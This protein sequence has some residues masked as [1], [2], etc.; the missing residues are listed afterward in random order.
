MHSF[1]KHLLRAY[2]VP[3]TIPSASDTAVLINKP[4]PSWSSHPRK[5]RHRQSQEKQT[6]A[7]GDG[8][9]GRYLINKRRP[10]RTSVIRWHWRK[11]ERSEARSQVAIRGAS[12]G[13][14]A[15]GMRRPGL[16]RKQ[17]GDCVAGS[18]WKEEELPGWQ[19]PPRGWGLAGARGAVW[20]TVRA[21]FT[22]ERAGKPPRL[23]HSIRVF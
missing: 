19:G 4:L 12:P 11:A 2:Y 17:R 23:C 14:K 20:A 5:S 13:T 1:E 22:S 16:L 9:G 18:E 10:A 8:M 15:L 3:G 7:T 21:G 6:R